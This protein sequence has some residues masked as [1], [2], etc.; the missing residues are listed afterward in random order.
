MNA[1]FSQKPP[2]VASITISPS[3]TVTTGA[4]FLISVVVNDG[5]YYTWSDWDDNTWA[6]VSNLIWGA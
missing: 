6:E 1:S 2:E 3:G 5:G 4:S